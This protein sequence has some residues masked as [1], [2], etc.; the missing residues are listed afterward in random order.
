MPYPKGGRADKYG[1]R[2]ENVWVIYQLLKVINEEIY[3]VIIEAIGDDEEGVD[4]WVNEKDGYREAQQCK[5]RN[6]SKEYWDISSLKA[7]EII[8]KS[9]KQLERS[10]KYKYLLVSPISCTMLQDLIKMARNTSGNPDEFLKYQIQKDSG[11]ELKKFFYNYCRELEL[12]YENTNELLKI[13]DYLQRTDYHQFPDSKEQKEQ[14]LDKIQFLLIGNKREIYNLLENLILEEDVLGKE[15]TSV[16][17]IRYLNDNGIILR[18]LANDERVLPRINEL[19]REY[20]KVFKPISDN[21]YERKEFDVCKKEILAGN[22]LI[23]HGRAGSGKSGCTQAIIEYCENNTL[24][25]I[26]IKLDKRIPQGSSEAFGRQLDLPTSLVYCLHCIS[27]NNNGVLILDQLDALRWTQSHSRSALDVCSEILR[28]I[29]HLNRERNRKISLVLVCRTYDLENDNNI[30]NIFKQDDKNNSTMIWKKIYVDEIEDRIVK[31]IVGN[32]YE[33]LTEKLKKILRIPSNLYI[34]EQLDKTKDYNEFSTANELLTAWWEQLC[35]KCS[36]DGVAE[37]ELNSLKENLILSLEKNNKLSIN[38]RLITYTQTSLEY[39]VSNGMLSITNNEISFVHQSMVDYFLV[40]NMFLRFFNGENI[41]IFMGE[42]EKQTPTRRYQVQMLLQG[43][44]ECDLDRFVDAGEEILKCGT[45]RFYIKYVFLEVLGQ[46]K[47][48]TSRMKKFIKDYL[49]DEKYSNHIV[50][51]VI[52]GH[53]IYVEFLINEGYIDKWYEQGEKKKNLAINLLAS[54]NQFYSSKLVNIIQK[55]AFVSKDDDM[56][57]IQCFNYDLT[58][59]SDE[60]FALRMEFYDKYPEI[61]NA[62]LNIREMF[63]N[64]EKR[65]IAII[66]CMLKHKGKNNGKNIYRYEEEFLDES[67]EII[68]QKGEGIIVELLPYVPLSTDYYDMYYENWSGERSYSTGLE[69]ACI[70]IL[71]KAIIAVVKQNPLWFWEKFEQYSGKGYL[72]INELVLCGLNEMSVDYSDKVIEYLCNDINKNIFDDTSGNKDKLGMVKNIIEKHSISC[73]LDKFRMLEEKLS[74]FHE[75]S[76]K[77]LYE[78]RVEVNR[79]NEYG[80]KVYWAFWGEVQARL[81]PMLAQGR[82]SLKTQELIQ[83]LERRFSGNYTLH[84][85]GLQ[86]HSGWVKSPISGK[87]NILSNRQWKQLLSNKKL[88]QRNRSRWINV[89]GGFIES[90]MEQFSTSFN[91][92][93]SKEPERFIKL[94]LEMVDEINEVYI[95]SLYSGLA[96]SENLPKVPFELIETIL[97]KYQSDNQSGRARYICDI[98]EKRKDDKWSEPII[99]ILKDIALNHKDPKEGKINV[100]SSEDKEMKTFNMLFSNSLNCVRGKAA[101]AMASLLWER[102]ELYLQ[103]KDIVDK[104]VNDINPA[105]KMATIEC[106]CPIYNIDRD[107]AS[108]K[109]IY[110]L[111]EDNRIAGHPRAKQFLFLLYYNSKENVLDIIRKCYYSKDEELT[112]L[113]AHCLSEMYILYDEFA[114]EIMD[115]E[116]INQN[117]SKGIIE[118]AILYFSRDQYPEKVKR[119]LK[120]FFSSDKDLEFPFVRLFYDNHIDFDRDL[121]FLLEMMQSK[122]SKRIIRAF[123]SYLE[124]NAMSVIDFSD[125]IIQMSTNILQRP[126]DDEDNYYGGIDDELSKLISV[127]YD[128]SSNYDGT[129]IVQQCL[130]IWDLMF[131]KRIGSIHRLSRQIL[132]I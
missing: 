39:L 132:Y 29:T 30:K 108:E 86:G 122:L 117:Q 2:Y 28:E 127:L 106:L 94:T 3:S 46:C 116:S 27:K 96:Y 5:G 64:S 25:Y 1:N 24:P 60:M 97:L 107:W 112:R 42:K 11:Q 52:R 31:D 95:D 90:S 40:E 50:E 23:I 98:I 58:N 109:V 9:K 47:Q 100:S 19:N 126:L 36:I 119:L 54:I 91:T 79:T 121:T 113:G 43:I 33:Q 85:N 72:L 67:S 111:K 14:I 114:K 68:V 61:I 93:V 13:I 80:Q 88:K 125:V 104:L 120:S 130:D 110:L 129:H 17:L 21:L 77:E 37:T 6:A 53:Q 84:M 7:R 71:K 92:A 124:E 56:K 82:I 10:N 41:V 66:N 70:S 20:N 81:L 87:E 55:Y 45:I 8:K 118:M 73:S 69:R 105:V 4:I 35:L 32:G 83:V 74:Y 115:V 75:K 123:I 102:P 101:S 76:E 22:S 57:L 15:I 48:L 38:K 34:W 12:D 63:K 59:D 18:D 62:H 78:R 16:M 89:E 128:E 99:S 26:A 65:A 131:E 103:F 49:E 44:A 51:N